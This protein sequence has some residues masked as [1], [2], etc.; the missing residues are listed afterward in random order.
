M[1]GGVKAEVQPPLAAR[2]GGG[3]GGSKGRGGNRSFSQTCC[4]ADCAEKKAANSKFCKLHHRQ[5]ENIKDQATRDGETE[6]YNSIM[7]DPDKAQEALNQHSKDNVDGRF[8]KRLIDWGMWKK[9]FGQKTSTTVSNVEEWMEVTAYVGWRTKHLP[10][11]QAKEDMRA[12][13]REEF[14][15]LCSQPGIEKEGAW[16]STFIWVNK[17]RRRLSDK[18]T[19]FDGAYEEGP[20]PLKDLTKEDRMV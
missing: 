1:G 17:K 12:E 14:R 18:D 16:P 13:M 9:R 10:E 5:A 15:K 11:C 3:G 8:R 2:R 20:K 19:Y 7:N 6:S 4:A